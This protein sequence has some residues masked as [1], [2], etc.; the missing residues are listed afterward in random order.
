MLL[1]SFITDD[2]QTKFLHRDHDIIE[3]FGGTARIGRMGNARGY[4]ALSHDME[5]DRSE[6]NRNC[7]NINGNAGFAPLGMTP[8]SFLKYSSC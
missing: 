4:F 8:T 5:Y 6:S 7:M 1:A 3:M 2:V